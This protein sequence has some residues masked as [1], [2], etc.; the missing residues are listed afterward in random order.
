MRGTLLVQVLARFA[1]TLSRLYRV[2][3]VPL[4]GCALV[5]PFLLPLCHDRHHCSLLARDELQMSS[6]E[7]VSD[8]E[9]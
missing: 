2:G 6:A 3:V 4:I 1:R 8:R 5:L 7:P 9:G